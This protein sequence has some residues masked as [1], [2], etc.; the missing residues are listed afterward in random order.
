MAEQVATGA[1][2]REVTPEEV[3]FYQEHGWVKLDKL[4]SSELATE[5]RDTIAS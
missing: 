2:A 1:V 4:I 3:A 5:M